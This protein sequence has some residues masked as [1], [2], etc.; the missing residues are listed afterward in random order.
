MFVRLP[1]ATNE[2]HAMHMGYIYTQYIKFNSVV[3]Q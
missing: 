2:M 3:D 1:D